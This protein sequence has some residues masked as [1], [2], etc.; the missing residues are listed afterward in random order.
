[1][2]DNQPVKT[3]VLITLTL[4]LPAATMLAQESKYATFR[5]A[6]NAGIAAVN[7]GDLAASREPLEAAAKLANTPRD[8]LRAH[9]ALMIPYRELPEIEPMQQAA[10]YV[11]ANNDFAATRLLTR[12]AMLSFIHR[13]GK[14]KAAVDAYEVRLKKTPD[15]RTVLF[16]LTEAYATY[17]KDP[18]RSALLAEKLGTIE[19]EAGVAQDVG[20]QAHLAQQ[21][22]KAG[23]WK[24]GAELYETIARID[25]KL[26]AWHFKEAAAAWL[27]SGNKA[28]ALLAAKKSEAAAHPENRG[29]LLTYFWHRGLADV[30]LDAGEPQLAIPHYEKAVAVSTIEGYTR[31]S[32]AKLESAKAAASK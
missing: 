22:V 21:Y 30:F 4:A 24:E 8:K 17:M 23:K 27:K 14:M 2:I 28:K 20:S 13:R 11:I 31:D 10:E 18:A 29:P 26:E 12:G 6:Y 19:K 5:E 1:M 25:P 15:D 16:V 32:R 3:L 7:G 9:E